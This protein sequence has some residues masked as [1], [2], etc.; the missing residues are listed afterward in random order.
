MSKDKIKE[1]AIQHFNRYG[2]EG[3]RMAKIAEE[4]GIRKQ[5]LSYHYSSKKELLLELYAE[6]V[7]SEIE[8]VHHYFHRAGGWSWEDRLY[9]FLVEHKNR[10]LM[11]PNV[12]LMFVF[13]FI[14]PLEVN[15]YVLSQYRR[16]L[17]VLKGELTALFEEAGHPS[18]EECSVAYVTLLDGLDVQLVYETHQSYERTMAIA[19]SVFLAGIRHV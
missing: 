1:I 18:P 2:Y 10:F 6:A 17:A 5:S 12:N 11:H 16:Y 15:D 7:Q 8:F 19:W 13:S 4:A 14:P 3:T 9:N